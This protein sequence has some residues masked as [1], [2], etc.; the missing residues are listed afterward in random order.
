MKNKF[1]RCEINDIHKRQMNIQHLKMIADQL[2]LSLKTE[3]AVRIPAGPGGGHLCWKVKSDKETYFIKQLDPLLDVKN[4]KNIARYELCES[5]AFRFAQQG[6][7]AVS[8]IRNDDKSVIILENNAYLVY[9]WVE[10]C[11]LKRNE[12][13]AEHAIKMAEIL[14]QIHLINLNVPEM[15][16]KID[17]HTNEKIVE[18][19]ERISDE[20]PISTT[21]RNNQSMI[22]DMNDRYHSAVSILKKKTVI[23]HGDIFP[24]NVIWQKSD[25]PFLIDWEAIKK[26][27]PTREVIRACFAWGGLD[28][29][30]SA[31]SSSFEKMLTTYIGLGGPLVKAHIGAALN[32][33]YGNMI[34]W[35][36]YNIDL[37]YAQNSCDRK[38][39]AINEIKGCLESGE[40]LIKLYPTLFNSITR[41]T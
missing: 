33:M 3:L 2:R 5:V 10:G 6:I 35:L 31:L 41:F 25:S 36:L 15:E 34:N 39:T 13:S 21:L 14:A 40:K 30:S 18:S 16:A 1:L 38:N 12:I 11:T 17:L 26:M 4:A 9:P 8:A 19:L 24:H 20:V 32:G 27:N 7:P 28:D 22:L 37:V 23:T 29:K